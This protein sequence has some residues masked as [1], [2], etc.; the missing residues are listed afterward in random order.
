MVIMIMGVWFYNDIII[1][2]LIRKAVT[3]HQQKS[4]NQRDVK[5]SKIGTA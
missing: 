2:P 5:M 4:N 3:K 1:M